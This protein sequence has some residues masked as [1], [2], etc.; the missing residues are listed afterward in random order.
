MP[1]IQQ[2]FNAI[3]NCAQPIIIPVSDEM[4]EVSYYEI[5]GK[6][7]GIVVKCVV[8]KHNF[9]VEN[10][11]I[12]RRGHGDWLFVNQYEENGFYFWVLERKM[13]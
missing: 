12:N 11:V 10:Y 5:T 1:T 7:H 13:R 4:R 8:P 2:R 9:D 6:H 3:M